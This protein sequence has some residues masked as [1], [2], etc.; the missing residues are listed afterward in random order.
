MK[1]RLELLQGTAQLAGEGLLGAVDTVEGMHLAIVE[2]VA[3]FVPFGGLVT[4]STGFVYARIRDAAQLT[5]RAADGAIALLERSGVRGDA[6]DI[7]PAQMAW[8]SALNGAIGDRLEASANPLAIPMRL[9]RAGQV[10]DTQSARFGAEVEAAGGTLY[11][12][13][14]GL[15][16][17]DLQWRDADGRDF[18]DRLAQDVAGHATRLRYNSGRRISA[19]GRDLST[20]LQQVYRSHTAAIRRIVLIGHSMGGLVCR[21]ACADAQRNGLDWSRVLSDV[22]C[23]GSPHLGAPLERLGDSLSGLLALTPYT[24]SLAAV[25]ETRSAGV[26]DLRHGWSS[27]RDRGATAT[28]EPEASGAKAGL[29]PFNERVRWYLVAATL[30][31][32]SVGTRARWLGDGLVPVPSALGQHDDPARALRV[33]RGHRRVFTQTGHMDLL[34]HAG[35]YAQIRDWVAAPLA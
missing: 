2:T 20:L 8:L 18:G 21:S 16:M 17:N 5:R 28:V 35:L 12:L 14:H 34:T 13:V 7:A 11:V 29:L 1:S 27:D 25:A 31:A 19:N 23:L 32:H 10:I 26:K 6:L 24:R 15:G 30:G 4:R 22:I 9:C 33:P 3:R